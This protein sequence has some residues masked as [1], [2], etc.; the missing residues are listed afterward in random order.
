MCLCWSINYWVFLLL[1]L[2]RVLPLLCVPSRT[3]LHP[4]GYDFQ[5][6][7][8][9][10][11]FHWKH[12]LILPLNGQAGT[13]SSVNPASRAM[14]SPTCKW[15]WFVQEQHGYR[16]KIK[17]LLLSFPSS[18]PLLSPAVNLINVPLF[19][20]GKET[21]KRSK[22]EVYF[23]SQPCFKL[24]WSLIYCLSDWLP[25]WLLPDRSVCLSRG[26]CNEN[27]RQRH[28]G[29]LAVEKLT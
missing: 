4:L 10:F 11:P 19:S 23:S 17:A 25:H 26:N 8:P 3:V 13:L 15:L 12:F 22:S 28:A 7:P 5:I 14:M 20:G 1:S 24:G 9:I 6:V 16:V 27:V 29:G 18:S 2:Q 21:L